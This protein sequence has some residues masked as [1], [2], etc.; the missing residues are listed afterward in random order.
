MQSEWLSDAWRKKRVVSPYRGFYVILSPQYRASGCLPAEWFIPDLMAHLNQ[1]YYVGLL[2][3]AYY[4]GAAH[5]APMVFQVVVKKERRNLN[6]GSVRVDFVRRC[7]MQNTPTEERNTEA[8]IIQVATSEATAFELIGYPH[9]CGYLNNVA[10]VLA[11][12]AESM[13]EELLVRE[14]RRNPLAWCQRL[15]YMLSLV[16]A[17]KMAAC[18]EPVIE[19]HNVFRVALAPSENTVG[20]PR[21]RRWNI[22]ENVSVEADTQST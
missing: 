2:S 17:G 22:I 12:L 3:A 16:G 18:L 15:G 1:P 13:K 8:G 7:D 5:Q 21:D 11:E 14:A 20:A 10:T 9:K 4:H 19:K 6:C